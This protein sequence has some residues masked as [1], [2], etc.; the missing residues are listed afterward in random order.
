MKLSNL[1]KKRPSVIFFGFWSSGSRGK[2]PVAYMLLT[3]TPHLA[4]LSSSVIA[5][6][7]TRRGRESCTG[8]HFRDESTRVSSEIIKLYL[9]NHFILIKVQSGTEPGQRYNC[10]SYLFVVSEVIKELRS[11]DRCCHKVFYKYQIK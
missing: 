10:L 7:L 2:S 8:R 1:F 3:C 5:H 4:Q 11:E 9:C 6:L